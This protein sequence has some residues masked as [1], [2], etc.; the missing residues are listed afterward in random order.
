[1]FCGCECVS[2]CVQGVDDSHSSTY[3]LHS[4]EWSSQHCSMNVYVTRIVLILFSP[5]SADF[6]LVTVHS[7]CWLRWPP[8]NRPRNNFGPFVM[9]SCEDQE[10]GVLRTMPRLKDTVISYITLLRPLRVCATRWCARTRSVGGNSTIHHSSNAGCHNAPRGFSTPQVN[11]NT[12]RIHRV[13][14]SSVFNCMLEI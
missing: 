13:S 9:L 2:V 5:D 10:T 14:L 12:G 1:V 7:Q 3:G 11:F 4:G 8:P 6:S